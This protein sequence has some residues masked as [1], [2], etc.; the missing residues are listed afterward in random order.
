MSTRIVTKWVCAA[1]ICATSL[2]QTHSAKPLT[3]CDVL[4]KL[5]SYRG[6]RI[7]V[8]GELVGEDE[9]SGLI[10]QGCQPLITDG[11]RWPSP[12]PIALTYP[13]GPSDDTKPGAPSPRVERVDPDALRSAGAGAKI[14]VTVVGR[15]ETRAPFPMVHLD[16]GKIRPYGYG[17]LA[18]CPAQ[19]VY[20]EIKDL[21]I[22][23]TQR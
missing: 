11:Y 9:G 17:H 12:S 3:V 16:G 15:L 18:A 14:Y 21:K 4:A 6:Q 5:P 8:R 1:L 7:V 2:S 10:G 20:E 23:P 19:I 22:V 13:G